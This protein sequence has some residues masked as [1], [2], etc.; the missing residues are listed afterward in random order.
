MELLEGG[1]LHD[2]KESH[3]FKESELAYVAKELLQGI[4]YI[5]SKQ[6]IHR[7]LKSSNIMM[8][9]K[10]DVKI[11]DFGLC[12]SIVRAKPTIVGS[13]H[14]IPPEMILR[15]HY[16]CSAD[17]WSF[18][19]CMLELCNKQNITD[20][21]KLKAM[22]L[23][24]TVGMPQPLDEPDRWSPEYKDFISSALQY[25]PLHRPTAFELLGHSFLKKAVDAKD[26][27][28]ILLHEVF[29]Q[30]AMSLF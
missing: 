29:L 3:I 1:T 4:A 26:T 13:A 6:L 2:A 28:A 25:L 21:K 16:D 19:I 22:F 9:K 10:G 20:I 14:W 12:C 11:I 8:C 15:H 7:D 30:K 23:V 18:G 5:H 17:I 24:G 27:M